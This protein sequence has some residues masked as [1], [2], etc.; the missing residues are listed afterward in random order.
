MR[1]RDTGG[2]VLEGEGHG[3]HRVQGAGGSSG[4]QYKDMADQEGRR[5]GASGGCEE[6][7]SGREG[8]RDIACP[9]CCW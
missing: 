1:G 4:V 8:G 5:G 2:G 7:W 9:S 6:G 3:V